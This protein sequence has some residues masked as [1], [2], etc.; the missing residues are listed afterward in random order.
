MPVDDFAFARGA[1]T[2]IASKQ[3][4]E[5][6]WQPKFIG[7]IASGKDPRIVP[8][9]VNDGTRATT[10]TELLRLYRERYVDVEP[11][12]SRS[13]IISQLWVLTK[14][15]GDLPRLSLADEDQVQLG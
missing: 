5:K 11:L 10:V 2:S 9:R 15:L 14:E 7:E 8:K 13:W 3:E 1:T 6:V 12:K 4:A